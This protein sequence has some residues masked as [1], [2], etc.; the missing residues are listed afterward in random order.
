[1]PGEPIGDKIS[2]ILVVTAAA[3]FF[4]WVI[5]SL[6]ALEMI[7]VR[8]RISRR[9][10]DRIPDSVE[11]DRIERTIRRC[12]HGA[13]TLRRQAYLI[14]IYQR[15]NSD[16]QAVKDIYE[17]MVVRLFRDNPYGDKSW[18]KEQIEEV[19]PRYWLIYGEIEERILRPRFEA[20]PEEKVDA[21]KKALL[22]LDFARLQKPSEL[23]GQ[24]MDGYQEDSKLAMLCVLGVQGELT[25]NMLKVTNSPFEVDDNFAEIIEL[26]RMFTPTS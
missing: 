20:I 6:I 24:L 9:F 17:N 18:I 16:N 12:I 21:A 22:Y 23:A 5:K 14:K 19:M 7:K 11:A 3:L 26:T 4:F 2:I 25:E 15:L 8:L 1:M 13:P 10:A